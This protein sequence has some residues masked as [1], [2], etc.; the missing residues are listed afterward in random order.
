[1]Q[2]QL[3]DHSVQT[4]SW[5]GD[6][7]V[8]W[9]RAGICYS[10]TGEKKQLNQYYF[11]YKFDTA[12]NSPDGQYVF[13]YEKLSTKGILIKN[14]EILREIN[15][16]YYHA[17]VYEYP[18]TFLQKDNI[19]YLIHCPISYCQ[20]D[21][22]NVETGEIL[23][24]TLN[25]KPTGFFHS[26]F[27]ISPNSIYLI[28][29]G[30]AWHPYDFVEIFNIED[31]FAN[32]LLLDTS[33]LI[34]KSDSEICTASFIN[35]YKVLIGSSKDTEPFEHEPS[36]NLKPGQ[37]AIWDLISNSISTP[38]TLDFEFGNLIAIN[39][40]LAW[41]TYKFPKIIDLV[42]GQITDKAE[43]VYSGEQKS[44]I[45]FDI[46]RKPQIVIDAKRKRLAIKENQKV[47]VLTRE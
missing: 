41:D 46:E 17:N 27:E 26:R 2:R 19:T 23:T 4:I 25:R 44:S 29:K 7:I 11:G 39:E 22:E 3:L 42:T 18:A 21:F 40:L 12:I 14:G 13:I 37:I 15:R 5:L 10:L 32:P 45:I 1:M 16:S 30:W 35:D 6:D 47:T 20:I 34:P 43:D 33:N 8:D 24:N 9:S 38:I 36:G 31:C 28:S